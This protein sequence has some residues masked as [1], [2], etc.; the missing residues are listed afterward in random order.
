MSEIRGNPSRKERVIVMSPHQAADS[1]T[2]RDEGGFR[3]RPIFVA[4]SFR[5]V[6]QASGYSSKWIVC[7]AYAGVRGAYAGRTQ[8]HGERTQTYAGRTQYTASTRTCGFLGGFGRLFE[9]FLVSSDSRI[10]RES[11]PVPRLAQPGWKPSHLG[12]PRVGFT[13]SPSCVLINWLRSSL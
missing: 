3:E 6:F 10:V 5:Q 11:P 4:P 9:H 13:I 8:A 1:R 12:C 7:R 2:D